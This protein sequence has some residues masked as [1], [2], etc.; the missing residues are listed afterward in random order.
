[1]DLV[2]HSFVFTIHSMLLP[3]SCSKKSISEEA[4]SL[5]V[6]RRSWAMA[7]HKDDIGRNNVGGSDEDNICRDYLRN[8]CR[9]GKKCKYKHTDKV[10]QD[11]NLGK[12][13]MK[14]ELTFCHDYQNGDCPRPLCR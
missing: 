7:H 6:W 9:R 11:A 8:V 3:G 14:S 2:Q 12:Q 4:F 10:G 1:M 5:V 13:G